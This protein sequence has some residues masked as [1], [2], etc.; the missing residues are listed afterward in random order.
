MILVLI[1]GFLS[2]FLIRYDNATYQVL[3]KYQ[4]KKIKENREVRT[5]F[6]GDSSLGNAID[7]EEFAGLSSTPTISCALTAMHGYAGSYNILKTAV[8]HHPEIKNVVLMN[9]LR[10]QMMPVSFSGY[11]RT[12]NSFN[13]ILELPDL[14]KINAISEFWLYVFSIEVDQFGDQKDLIQNDYI[15]QGKK[16]QSVQI[17]KGFGT[18]QITQNKNK[19]LKKIVHFC[20]KKDLNLIYVH[21]PIYDELANRS[22]DYIE[23]INR[24]ISGTGVQL[25]PDIV[26]FG[27][28]DMGD[29]IDHIEPGSKRAYTFNYYDLLKDRLVII[30]QNTILE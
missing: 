28:S 9:S 16:R 14:E 30:P 23:T 15:K 24:E 29:Y 10:M 26:S 1:I 3:Y 17:S 21:G 5:L 13:D 2:Y 22:Q 12:M 25:V 18:D 7:S 20:R 6:I 27:D 4:L 19:F 8:Q 11:V